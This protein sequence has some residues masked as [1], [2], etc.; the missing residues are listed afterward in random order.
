MF[1][2]KI[3]HK[4]AASLNLSGG[5]GASLSRLS[6]LPQANVPQGFII[7]TEFFKKYISP[8]VDEAQGNIKAAIAGMTLPAE[9]EKLIES[10]YIDMGDQVSVAVRSS[11][12]AEDLPD[13]SFAGQQDTYLNV[14]GL[15]AVIKAVTG[16]FASLYN[17]R[18]VSY[19]SKNK[20]DESE[21]QMAVVVQKM[22]EA[23]A[24]GV[25]F[26]ADPMTSDRF[27]MAIEAV[28]GLGEDLVSGHKTPVT[29]T[30]R[31]SI[32][33]KSGGT[34]FLAKA[35]LTSLINIGK[36][37]E[38]EYGCPQDIEWCF[39]GRQFY[40][41]QSR[42]I[43]TLFPCPLSPDGFKRCF[44]SVGHLQM[45][46]DTMLPLG[47]S[48]WKLMS[49]T[50]KITEIGGRP[51]MEI[52]HNLNSPVGKALVR[53]KL[54]NSDELMDSAFNQ[55][56]SRK[57]Y[58][59]SIPKG[60][61]SDFA[62]PRDVGK[63]ILGGLKIYRKN[64]PAIIDGYNRRMEAKI[65]KVRNDLSKLTG[66]AVIDYIIEDTDHLMKS[67]FDPEGMG[68]LMIAFFLTKSID[69]AGKELLGRDHISA[70]VSKSIKNNITS[71]MGFY[72]SRIADSARDFPEVVNYLETAGDLFSLGQLREKQ[73]EAETAKAFEAFFS[74]YGMRC[75]GEIDI[76]KPRFSEEPA[77]IIPTVLADI[78]LPK[79][80]AEQKFL[81][82]K[83]E[84]DEAVKSLISAARK[85]WGIKKAKKLAKQLSFFRNFSGLRESPK[86]YWMKRYWE[87]KQAIMR[88]C[89]QL[90]LA[91]RLRCMED[92][93]YLRLTELSRLLAGEYEPNYKKIDGLKKD[94]EKY[95]SLTPPRL[96]FSDG[97][98]V[99]GEYKRDVPKG[100]L[101]GLA[102]SS[103]VAQGRARVILDIKEAGKIEKGDILV[104]KF[105]DPSWTPAFISIGGLVTEVGGMATHGA[106]ITR[107]YGLPAVVGVSD[108]T[109]LIKDGDLI[110]VNGDMG[111]VKC[112]KE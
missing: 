108:A 56:L 49:K 73:G 112:I 83:Q 93:F 81:E 75:P 9:A 86:Y 76:A 19:R 34:P 105:T 3:N 10:A 79:G 61:K 55:V 12:T 58:I 70:D 7:T 63:S 72:V 89:E 69:K 66:K 46:T 52:T 68:P 85:K 25:M 62:I 16:C 38:R 60:Q 13:A 33:Q 22:V 31:G 104:T 90:V 39:D 107:E 54:S 23:K 111:Y 45:M 50:V 47:I 65:D 44:I 57:D 99:E 17:D 51:Y 18:A 1:I 78:K 48:F 2:L 84:S 37:I 95:A 27:T 101:P 94:Y 11:A 29:W 80:H 88:E 36:E 32:R 20:F 74:R 82:G 110:R 87:Y 40:I 14:S 106:V 71:E 21:I 98:V 4:E 77:K 42:P 15:E 91:G 30:F 109:K 97:E 43:T 28:E 103:G 67:L 64:D 8:V 24:A 6:R 59:K 5:K 100:A 41:V 92:I 96:I 53:Q 102:V 35:Q 26:T